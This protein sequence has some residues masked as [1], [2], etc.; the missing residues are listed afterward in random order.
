MGWQRCRPIDTRDANQSCEGNYLRDAHRRAFC[1]VFG[2]SDGKAW[3][4]M[5]VAL[6]RCKKVERKRSESGETIG[7]SYATGGKIKFDQ[8]YQIPKDR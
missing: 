3:K 4:G 2:E 1:A 8:K 5:K 7:G 6:S